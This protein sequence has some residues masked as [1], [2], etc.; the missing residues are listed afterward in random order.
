[1]GDLGG[2]QEDGLLHPAGGAAAPRT[3]RTRQPEA[4]QERKTAQAGALQIL[5]LHRGGHLRREEG[6]GQGP[7]HEPGHL[8]LHQERGARPDHRGGRNGEELAGNS[9]R[10][11]GLLQR[12]QD[13]VLQHEQAA[14]RHRPRTHRVH[15]AQAF[16]Q[17]RADRP[18]DTGRLRNES[19]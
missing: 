5:R 19:A 16:R 1:M 10:T 17:N 18:P 4:E 7:A 11:P 8:R 12:N 6:R 13:L 2:D 3:G 14:G 9:P 15:A